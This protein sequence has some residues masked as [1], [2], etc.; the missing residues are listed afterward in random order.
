MYNRSGGCFPRPFPTAGPCLP[1]PFPYPSPD[2]ICVPI[3][4][5]RHWG[6]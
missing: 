1:D 2:C 6:Y 3:H 4:K 5:R